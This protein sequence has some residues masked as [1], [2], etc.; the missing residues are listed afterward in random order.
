[1]P[2]PICRRPLRFCS[3]NAQRN[4][5]RAKA[6]VDVDDREAGCAACECGVQRSLP[7]R[8]DAVTHRRRYGDHHARDKPC[9]HAEKRAFHPGNSD[10]HAM[11]AYRVEMLNE[12][13]QSGHAHVDEARRGFAGEC[14]RARRFLCNRSVRSAAAY[15][16]DARARTGRRRGTQDCGARH[17]VVVERLT[18]R[19]GQLLE[20]CAIEPGQQ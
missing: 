8:R 18:H 10:D 14:E 9:K 2:D 1:M 19:V 11:L 17:R 20:L 4:V 12:P 5:R 16:C 15:D 13:P 3:E 6:V 7:S